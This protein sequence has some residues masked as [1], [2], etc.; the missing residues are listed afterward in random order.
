MLCA[1]LFLI[2]IINCVF[3]ETAG[4]VH[5][6]A[7][8]PVNRYVLDTAD[9]VF[10]VSVVTS[11]DADTNCSELNE[12]AISSPKFLISSSE[13]SPVVLSG[14]TL[15][16]LPYSALNC[17]FVLCAILL[18]VISCPESHCNCGVEMRSSFTRISDVC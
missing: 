6:A 12:S 2:L 8:D 17:D 15:P 5:V 13:I 9:S 3:P 11:T 10:V 14:K 7:P 1:V 16:L 18:L 4:S